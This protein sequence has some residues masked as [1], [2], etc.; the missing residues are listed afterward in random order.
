MFQVKDLEKT[1]FHELSALLLTSVNVTGNVCSKASPEGK[2]CV[3]ES[4]VLQ[5]E[6]SK[7]SVL[8]KETKFPELQYCCGYVLDNN[9]QILTV[10]LQYHH[11]LVQELENDVSSGEPE[12]Y[13]LVSI[14]H[15]M[16]LLKVVLPFDYADT[17]GQKPST[18]CTHFTHP[19]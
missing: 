6:R 1:Q 10:T 8:S 2:A 11:I 16:T 3:Q 4:R 13:H 5:S 12:I 17:F 14:L 9:K 18:P 19:Y 15:A 7:L